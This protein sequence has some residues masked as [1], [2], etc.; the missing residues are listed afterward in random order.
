MKSCRAL[1]FLSLWLMLAACGGQ[2]SATPTVVVREPEPTASSTPRPTVTAVP[3]SIPTAVPS[4][5]PSP[6]SSP[7]P[8]PSLTVTPMQP[9][10]TADVSAAEQI[11]DKSWQWVEF[12][13]PLSGPEEIVGPERYQIRLQRDGR[14]AIQADCASGSGDLTVGQGSI[15]IAPRA[16]ATAACPADSLAA[17]FVDYLGSAVIWFMDGDDLLFDLKYDSGTMRFRAVPEDVLPE[18][19]G[20]GRGSEMPAIVEAI[21][22]DVQGVAQSYAW[23][24][25][26]GQPLAADVGGAALPAHILLTFDGEDPQEVLA[27]NGRRLYIFPVQRYLAEGGAAAAAEMTRLR[28]LVD[29]ADGRATSPESPMPLLPL[30]L[31][32]MDRWVQFADLNFAQGAGVRY[33]SDSPNRQAIGP[34]TNET[35]AYYYQGLS[36][37]GRFYISLIWPVR[38]PSLPDTFEETDEDVIARATNSAAYPTYLQQTQDL[39]NAL[40]SSAWQ[41]DL[42]K[43]DVM[44]ASLV[45]K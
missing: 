44:I 1:F 43:L 18:A 36:L 9:T 10:P 16:I 32:L 19:T 31:S 4:P 14:V 39:L 22:L 8:T 33:V 2:P 26:D 13:S 6:T 41:P 35:T 45:L 30:S 12:T 27:N 42:A 29:E 25:Q 23:Q 37:D 3:S 17:A 24:A 21:T 7:E 34:W 5:T 28:A 40:P 38:T 20:G 15:V 11:V